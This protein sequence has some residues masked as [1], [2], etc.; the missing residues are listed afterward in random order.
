MINKSVLIVDDDH[1]FL[2]VMH[3]TMMR[4][5]YK[6]IHAANCTKDAEVYLR[7]HRYDLVI[8]DLEMP[9]TDGY[10]LLHQVRSGRSSCDS[11]TPILVLSGHAEGEFIRRCLMFDVSDYL[12]KP[13]KVG[14]LSEK[15]S[16]SM[17]KET[18]VK[19]QREYDQLFEELSRS[20]DRHP[21]SVFSV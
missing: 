18:N 12:L 16:S 10:V 4:E 8:T 6:N 19:S 11:D 9:P 5:G 3:S 17:E 1:S 14:S 21:S 15:I 13:F 7:T 20:G 2:K